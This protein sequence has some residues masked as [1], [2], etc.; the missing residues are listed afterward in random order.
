MAT[1]RDIKGFQVQSVETDPVVNAGSWASGGN[2][3]TARSRIGGSTQATLTLSL[4]HI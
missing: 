2:L 3:N 4:I 1:Y